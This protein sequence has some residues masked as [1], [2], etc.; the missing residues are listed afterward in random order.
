MS[1][2]LRIKEGIDNGSITSSVLIT[3]AGGIVGQGIIKSLKLAN[4]VSEHVKYR[5]IAADISVQAAGIYR[6]DR[7]FLVPPPS[8]ADYVDSIIRIVRD[9]NIQAIYVGSDQELLVIGNEA[10][11]IERETEAKVL[12]NPLKIINIGRD[13]WNTFEF[14]KANKLPCALSCLP[15]DSRKF[16][17]D[18]GFPLVVKPREGYGSLHF[19]IVNNSEEM[20][21]ALSSIRKVGWNPILQEYIAGDDNEF[22]SGVTMD[23]FAKYV[24]SSISIKKILKHGQTYKAFVDD[25][26]QIRRFSEETA[27]KLGVRGAINIQSK[28]EDEEPKIFEINPRFSATTPIRSTAG[29]NEP[30]IVFRNSVLG[31]EIRIKHYEKLICMRYWNEVYIP[32]STYEKA[33]NTGRIVNSDSFIHNYF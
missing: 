32:Y 12:S 22:T 2:K 13:K 16:I 3:A 24:M 29:I 30:D 7:G 11:R 27:L 28:L 9:E 1:E 18:V 31:E 4:Q 33:S 20:D 21:Y 5:I 19:Y 14:L 6:C 8:S 26:K 23:R 15:E 10:E 17:Q 25:F